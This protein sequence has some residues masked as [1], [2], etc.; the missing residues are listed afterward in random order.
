LDDFPWADYEPDAPVEPPTFYNVYVEA[1]TE[2][3]Q[4]IDA[5]QLR[6]PTWIPKSQVVWGFTACKDRTQLV[7]KRIECL[8]IQ[9][10]FESVLDR[11]GKLKARL[12]G[13]GC[14]DS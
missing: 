8:A 10:W 6:A 7:G 4:R 13:G 1:E 2:L 3:A 9:E 14:C 12:G 5:D 11:E